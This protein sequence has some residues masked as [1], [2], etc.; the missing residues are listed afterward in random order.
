MS[1][2]LSVY[3]SGPIPPR[4]VEN[5]SHCREWRDLAT[6]LFEDAGWI[7]HNPL[8]DSVFFSEDNDD[9]IPTR[10][11]MMITHS[12][13]ILVN[14][15]PKVNTIGTPMEVIY[16]TQMGKPV[17]WFANTESLAA[18]LSQ[19]PWVR[20][21]NDLSYV[22][23]FSEETLIDLIHWFAVLDNTQNSFVPPDME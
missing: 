12:D 21:H 14:W 23:T 15:I 7:V 16:A 17:I 20:Q 6:R 22:G 8:S 5:Y 9:L 3:L 13:L 19:N 18:H 1:E 10:D 11:L 2:P 4:T